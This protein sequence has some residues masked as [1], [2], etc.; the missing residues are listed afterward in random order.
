MLEC[1]GHYGQ[2]ELR[3]VRDP[4]RAVLVDALGTTL[5]ELTPQGDAIPFDFGAN[6]LLH[7]RVEFR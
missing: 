3:C 1:S 4:R 5:T 7:L 2:A 6:D